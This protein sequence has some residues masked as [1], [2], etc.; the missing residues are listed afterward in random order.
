M[1]LGV[2]YHS[3]WE[4]FDEA[5]DRGMDFDTNRLSVAVTLEQLF[6]MNR[7]G[8]N[9]IYFDGP[10]MMMRINPILNFD[11][12]RLTGRQKSPFWTLA[13]LIN[14]G[15]NQESVKIDKEGFSLDELITREK[16][17]DILDKIN[18][19]VTISDRI[20]RKSVEKVLF[21]KLI[22]G[23]SEITEEELVSEI[24]KKTV[25]TPME[26][27][28]FKDIISWFESPF[29]NRLIKGL[30]ELAMVTEWRLEAPRIAMK[31]DVRAFELGYIM[32][33]FEKEGKSRG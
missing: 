7:Q 9:I 25:P 19:V 8:N 16:T 3:P 21:N 26:K 15:Y 10:K 33:F 2:A 5:Y 20:K 22:E 6:Q 24:F 14:T 32:A 13:R 30:K 29:C 11:F 12:D 17:K 28:A 18:M 4:F 31:Y 1:I 27:A 23:I